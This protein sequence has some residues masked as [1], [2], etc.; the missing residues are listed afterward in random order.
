MEHTSR[1]INRNFFEIFVL[2]FL[3]KVKNK[4]EKFL[5]ESTSFTIVP[6]NTPTKD[7]KRSYVKMVNN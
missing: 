1:R 3:Y 5:N 4:R 6:T 2:T 7:L